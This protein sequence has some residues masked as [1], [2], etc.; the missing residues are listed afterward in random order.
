M[1]DP[2]SEWRYDLDD[3]D[4]DGIVEDE[5]EDLQPGSPSAENALFVALGV[6]TTLALVARMVLLG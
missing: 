1:T 3:V 4:E 2:D 6:L 5:P